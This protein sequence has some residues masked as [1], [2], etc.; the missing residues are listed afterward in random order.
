MISGSRFVMAALLALGLASGALALDGLVKRD[1]EAFQAY[2]SVRAASLEDAIA[3]RDR[4]EAKAL[5]ARLHD[6]ECRFLERCVRYLRD[7]KNPI[8]ASELESYLNDYKAL[9]LKDT[10]RVR[11]SGGP[12]RYPVVEV[13]V[14]ALTG[15]RVPV[16]GSIPPPAPVAPQIGTP[17]P[18]LPALTA[19]TLVPKV[20]VKLINLDKADLSD[21]SVLAS[22]YAK[23]T[24]LDS[25][26]T[27]STGSGGAA[28]S[29]ADDSVL[30]SQIRKPTSATGAGG[31]TS[32]QSAAASA[33]DTTLASK[34]RVP[35]APS[36]TSALAKSK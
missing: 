19:N 4:E 30:A 24:N 11:R 23:P 26:K 27:H 22:H 6:E 1:L 34:I 25:I 3:R 20:S 9:S 29:S 14:A 10:V 35:S 17:V 36:N 18:S 2:E 21:Q 28:I 5:A 7:A 15:Q 13:A 33:S 31:A 32:S 16:P 12:G 8:V